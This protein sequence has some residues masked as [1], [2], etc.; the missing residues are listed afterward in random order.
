[1]MN[2]KNEYFKQL[3]Y[4]AASLGD[5]KLSVNLWTWSL[6]NWDELPIELKTQE[7]PSFHLFAIVFW[8]GNF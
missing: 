7:T 6:T 8:L 4:F 1:M 3:I 5:V 2:K